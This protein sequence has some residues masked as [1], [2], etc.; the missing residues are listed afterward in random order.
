MQSGCV[1]SVVET[2]TVLVLSG[3]LH[4]HTKLHTKLFAKD[5]DIMCLLHSGSTEQMHSHFVVDAVPCACFVPQSPA[6]ASCIAVRFVLVQ[7]MT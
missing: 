3:P 7:P 2:D 1:C 6:T 5:A 4:L